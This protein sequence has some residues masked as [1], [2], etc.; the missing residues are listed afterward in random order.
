MSALRV[1]DRVMRT[2]AQGVNTCFESRMPSCSGKATLLDVR[3]MRNRQSA[4]VSVNA[5]GTVQSLV[6]NGQ[7]FN[8]IDTQICR[9]KYQNNQ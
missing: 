3:T 1:G 7:C 6:K 5:L 9:G 8:F 4:S 2:S